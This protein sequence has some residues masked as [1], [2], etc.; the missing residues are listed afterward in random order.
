[1]Y[2]YSTI[3]QGLQSF[4]DFPVAMYKSLLLPLM[5]PVQILDFRFILQFQFHV[6]ILMM[7][8]MGQTASAE[9]RNQAIYT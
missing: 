2:V 9:C 3:L 4:P 6:G 5:C 7:E 1:M 8:K